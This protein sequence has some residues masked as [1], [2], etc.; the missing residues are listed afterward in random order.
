MHVG[1]LLRVRWANERETVVNR[2]RERMH[3]LP[4]YTQRLE[5]TPLGLANPAWV[6]DESFDAD[7]HVRR[8]AL[9]APGGTRSCASWSARCV[10]APRPHP[11]RSGSSR[12]WKDCGRA[13]GDR[14]EDASRAGGRHRRRGREH[15]DP[16]PVAATAGHPPPEPR[17]APERAP[18]TRLD[19][20]DADRVGTTRPS[21]AKLAARG[22]GSRTRR[23][24]AT[25]PARCAAR[26]GVVGELA[27][28]RPAAP[29][30]RLNA[31]IGRERLFALARGRLDDVKAVRRATGATVNDVLLTA[32]ALML[33]DY[34]GDEAPE[35]RRGAR[36]RSCERTR[37]EV[38]SATASRRVRGPPASRRAA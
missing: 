4:R 19:Q 5:A 24:A 16:R 33:S 28:V 10:G 21:R 22:G 20:L 25:T 17:D 18:A 12:W 32:V 8:V 7:R 3:L 14:G 37:S 26:P 9:P 2:L 11:G 23:P 15:G 27:R 6:H 29:D 38:S 13:L 30:T 31:E 34:L 1:G 35:T 36:A